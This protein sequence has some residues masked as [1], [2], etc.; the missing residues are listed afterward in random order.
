MK[1][2]LERKRLYKEAFA[3]LARIN[4][5]LSK[6]REQHERDSGLKKAA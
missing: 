5:L 6:A 2:Q 1:N 4:E 3:H